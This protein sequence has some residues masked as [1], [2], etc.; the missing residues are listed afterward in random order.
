MNVEI[1]TLAAK[2]LH[3]DEDHSYSITAEVVDESRR[4]IVGAGNVLVARKP[5]KVY[6]WVDRGHYRVGDTVH[7]SFSAFTLDQKPVQGTG[8]LELR[9]IAY[10]DGKPVESI[11]KTWDLNTDAEGRAEQQLAASAPGQYRLSYT[12]TD[13]DQHTIEGGYVFVVRGEGFDGRE[14]RFNDLELV[15]DQREYAPGETVKLMVSTNRADSAVVLFVRAVNGVCLTP[16]VIR[17]K[18][19]STIEEIG[20]VQKD[21][22]NFFIEAFTVADGRYH[23]EVREV[24]VPPE[25]RVLDVNVEASKLEY[26]PGEDARLQV[27]LTDSQGKPFVGSTVLTV[28]DRSLEYIS[29]GSNVPDI[30]EFFWEMAPPPPPAA[31]IQPRPP[32]LQPAQA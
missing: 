28:Y 14:F 27:K 21:M 18:G 1:D 10:A 22:P 6:T 8:K 32:L 26:K 12:L 17:L 4:T 25:T 13:S 15:T 20:V 19:K 9:Q 31:P 29:G 3:G 7:A 11:V 2:E 24:I 23:Q 16:K 5:F 30:R